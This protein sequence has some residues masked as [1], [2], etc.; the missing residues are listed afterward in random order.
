MKQN[1]TREPKLSEEMKKI[2]GKPQYRN[3]VVYAYNR[4]RHAFMFYVPMGDGGR[5]LLPIG[6]FTPQSLMKCLMILN[7]SLRILQIYLV[8]IL[9]CKIKNLKKRA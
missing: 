7:R 6:M 1:I 8:V 5:E 4:S 3:T 9:R 2:I